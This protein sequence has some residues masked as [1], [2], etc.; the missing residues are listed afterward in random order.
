MKTNVERGA[1]RQPEESDGG[2]EEESEGS[3]G[4]AVC[5]TP[6][7]QPGV[8]RTPKPSPVDV[9]MAP[10]H[11]TSQSSDLIQPNKFNLPTYSGKG[12]VICP[13]PLTDEG[14]WGLF[15]L[16]LYLLT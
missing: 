15:C 2:A 1:E 16:L 13:S 7:T 4:G 5:P 6:H 9:G 8:S 3:R 14:T 11:G 12:G 10:Q